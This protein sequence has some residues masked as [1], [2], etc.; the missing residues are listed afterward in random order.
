MSKYFPLYLTD[1]ELE[2]IRLCFA[3]RLE[4]IN[5][6][7]KQKD[8]TKDQTA[9]LFSAQAVLET[10]QEKVSL[11]LDYIRKSI[12]ADNVKREAVKLK[13]LYERFATGKGT[14]KSE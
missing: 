11:L 13:C 12:E 8:L 5:A 3:S 4:K 7:Q 6:E 10:V 1:T 9:G 14:D 2:E